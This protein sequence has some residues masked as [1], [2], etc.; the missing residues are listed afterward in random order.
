MPT[1]S[2]L[3]SCPVVPETE[4]FRG[5][6][7]ALQAIRPTDVTVARKEPQTSAD[8]FEVEGSY[9]CNQWARLGS[10]EVTVIVKIQPRVYHYRCHIGPRRI[11]NRDGG[12]D[13]KIGTVRV[14]LTRLT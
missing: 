10:I 1:V 11:E 5:L 6:V 2:V 13:E 3:V 9:T 8:D 7:K 4:T 14:K 12:H